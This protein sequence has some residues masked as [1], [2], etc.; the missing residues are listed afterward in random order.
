ME[1]LFLYLLI[2][3]IGVGLA[4]TDLISQ[5]KSELTSR[6]NFRETSLDPSDNL[7]NNYS[8][9]SEELFFNENIILENLNGP[10]TIAAADFDDDGD[11][12][13]VASSFDGN[14]IA[15]LE[16]DGCQNFTPH[17][18]IENFGQPR[19]DVAHIDGDLDYDIIAASQS[20]DKISWFENDGQANF[21][22]HVI[23]NNWESAGIVYARDPQRGIDLDINEDGYTDFIATSPSPGN[24]ISWFEN[25]GNQNFIEHVLK[26]NWYWVRRASAYDIDNDNDMDVVAAAK[27]G[28]II[29]FENDGEENFTEHIV[30]SNWGEPNAVLA[31][32]INKDGY[33]DLVA[34]SVVANEVVWFEND[35]NQ[36][37][38]K[39]T[40][41]EQYDG[42]YGLVISDFDIDNDFDIAATA[43]IGGFGSVF[44]NDGNQNFTEHIFCNTGYDLL[45]LF[46]ID[47]DKDEDLDILGACYA[48]NLPQIRWWE[49]NQAVGV[50]NDI[51]NISKEFK[52]SQNYPNPFNPTTKISY[53]IPRR[54]FVSLTVYD[55]LGNEI[56]ILVNEE[57]SEGGYEIEF[58]GSGLTSG[59]YLYQLRTSDFMKTNK[60][61]L[62]K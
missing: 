37:F 42:A 52:L 60:M 4:V 22:E 15:W 24:K 59:L 1:K 33:I 32:D 12:D 50:Y 62:M 46:V 10:N 40:I 11:V 58:D 13:V 45:H 7:L 18:I 2:C 3:V 28:E 8:E 34:T 26:E 43:W 51:P 61:I 44:E 14:Y 36:N 21:I 27:V 57:K 35:G 48:S 17:R 31:E 29:W 20:G 53:Q 30:I 5:T 25:D 55:L 9:M 16:N 6:N 47:I 54:D 56:S 19:V 38:T 41:K 23:I 39:H 49:N